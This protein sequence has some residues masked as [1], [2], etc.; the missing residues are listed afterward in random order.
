[1]T[2]KRHKNLEAKAFKR[3][4]ELLMPLLMD[5]EKEVLDLFHEIEG[6]PASDKQADCMNH[7][8]NLRWRMW[9]ERTS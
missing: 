7:A 4:K 9:K 8:S 1:M 5:Y 3:A 2:N 6:L